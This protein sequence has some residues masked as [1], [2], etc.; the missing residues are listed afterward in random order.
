MIWL[1]GAAAIPTPVS[2]TSISGPSPAQHAARVTA[3]RPIR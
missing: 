1:K 2:V 3:P